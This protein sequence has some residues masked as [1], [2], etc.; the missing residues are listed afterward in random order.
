ME[1]RELKARLKR[2]E[3]VFGTWSHIP[4]VQVV[5]IIGASGLDFIVFDLEHGPHG[6]SDMPALYCAA[7]ARGLV[8]VTRVPSAGNSNILRCLDSGAK[9]IMV[10]HVGSAAEASQC[11]ESMVYG[12]T[13][14]NRGV[15]T[16]TRSSMFD[17]QN[18]RR[19]LDSQNDLITSV[20]MIEDRAGVEALDDICR[21]PGLD[22]V[23]VGIYD[24]SQSLGLNGNLDD[25]KFLDVFERTV[26]RIAAHGVAVGCYAPT[27]QAAARLLDLGITFITLCVDGAMLRRSYQTM[28]S[29]LATLR[30]LPS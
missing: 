29:D 3:P 10:P 18:E 26:K 2:R 1:A 19:H 11:L 12:A 21:L 13:S 4:S 6:F 23:F 30:P 5:E 28:L 25:P 20:L 22:V 14:R 7:E 27:A 16:L 8:P 17:Y 9:G 24:L 15:A